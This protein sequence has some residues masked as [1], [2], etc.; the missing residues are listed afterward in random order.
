[1]NILEVLEVNL[2]DLHLSATS[3]DSA[4]HELADLLDS[5]GRL[6][7]KAKFIESV[8][9]RESVGETG[10]GNS[11]AIPHGL[12]DAVKNASVAIGKVS[13]PIE[14]ESIDDQP[15]KLVFMLAVPTDN[16]QNTHLKILSQLAAVLAYEEHIK[17]LLDCKSKEEFFELFKSYYEARLK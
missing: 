7:D 4:I 1:M 13:S 11:I 16:L 17:A 12:T 15:V 2:I 10:M 3:K 14:W 5:N 9:E 6:H 8:Y